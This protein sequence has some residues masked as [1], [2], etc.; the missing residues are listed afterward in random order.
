MP[1]PHNI[2]PSSELEPL[3]AVQ[4][5]LASMAEI[6]FDINMYISPFLQICLRRGGLASTAIWLEDPKMNLVN[7]RLSKPILVDDIGHLWGKG[8]PGVGHA[9]PLESSPGLVA[10]CAW[11]WPLAQLQALEVDKRT[12]LVT[13]SILE[14]ATSSVTADLK[15]V[16]A[17]ID[18]LTYDRA[19]RGD[20]DLRTFVPSCISSLFGIDVTVY[21]PSRQALQWPQ[22]PNAAAQNPLYNAEW[23]VQLQKA[24]LTAER[25]VDAVTH[26]PGRIHTVPNVLVDRLVNRIHTAARDINNE[27][28]TPLHFEKVL[29]DTVAALQALLIGKADV[30]SWLCFTP[31]SGQEEE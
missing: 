15:L 1:P 22:Q 13:W 17:L 26:L 3:L 24:D 28:K 4:Y 10:N 9:D 18:K 5:P 19:S 23:K 7:S 21:T 6:S 16:R 14:Q 11:K 30:V 8:M 12:L 31:A 29:R 20:H 2:S 25:L 27:L